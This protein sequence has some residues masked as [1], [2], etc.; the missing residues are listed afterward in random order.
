MTRLIIVLTA[1]TLLA[2]SSCRGGQPGVRIYDGVGVVV[3]IDR[4]AGTI[5]INHE[6]I[7]DFMTAMTMSFKARRPSLLDNLA[8]GDRVEFQ[9][10]DDGSQVVLVKINKTTG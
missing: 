10:R 6:D 9:L 4:D 2:A 7:K 8:P 3:S 1:L 5:E